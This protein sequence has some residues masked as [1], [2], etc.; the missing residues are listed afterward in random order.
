MEFKSKPYRLNEEWAKIELVKDVTAMASRKSGAIVLGVATK[1][2]LASDQDIAD[3]L[4]PIPVDE[5]SVRQIRAV[6]QEWVYPRLEI[7][8]VNYKVPED[9]KFLW[10]ITPLPNHNHHPYLLQGALP[11]DNKVK[12]TR[13]YFG[14]FERTDGADNVHVPAE[15]VHSLIQSFNVERIAR[16]EGACQDVRRKPGSL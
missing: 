6:I 15:R 14:L 3:T 8:I 2:D 10:S 7:D 11:P 13:K 9:D 12:I 5:V 16:R 1:R 4:R